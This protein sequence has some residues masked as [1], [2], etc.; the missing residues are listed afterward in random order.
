MLLRFVGAHCCDM[1]LKEGLQVTGTVRSLAKGAALQQL[2]KDKPFNLE[3]VPNLEDLHGF[4]KVI[5]KHAF[6]GILHVASPVTLSVLLS[7]NS[8]QWLRPLIQVMGTTPMN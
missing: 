6:D 1:A 7:P 8:I 4:D 5:K 3:I 2:F